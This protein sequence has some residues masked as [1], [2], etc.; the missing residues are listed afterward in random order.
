VGLIER[1][2]DS[3]TGILIGRVNNRQATDRGERLI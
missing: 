1:M 2:I 3:D